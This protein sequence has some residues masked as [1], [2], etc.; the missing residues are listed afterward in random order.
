MLPE[1][2][3][4]GLAALKRKPVLDKQ[5]MHDMILDSMGRTIGTLI[6]LQD[7]AGEPIRHEIRLASGVVIEIDRPV[8]HVLW[9]ERLTTF[10]SVALQLSQDYDLDI[11]RVLRKMLIGDGWVIS[12]STLKTPA[13]MLP[14][15]EVPLE[16]LRTMGYAL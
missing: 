6:A 11:D 12:S 3:V 4:R 10:V 16:M 7:A 13:W 15:T 8:G 5:D 14:H 2:V 9:N 1:R